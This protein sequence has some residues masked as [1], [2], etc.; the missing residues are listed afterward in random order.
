MTEGVTSWQCSP[1]LALSPSAR[2]PPP[3]DPDELLAR[4]IMLALVGDQVLG[5]TSGGAPQPRPHCMPSEMSS[6]EARPPEPAAWTSSTR[7]WPVPDLPA[8][9]SQRTL[10]MTVFETPVAS[11]ASVTETLIPNLPACV[12]ICGLIPLIFP[13]VEVMPDVELPSPQATV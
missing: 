10:I 12:Y 11:S 8:A 1:A 5:E 13:S 2:A 7:V 9:E 6:P 4:L 3:F